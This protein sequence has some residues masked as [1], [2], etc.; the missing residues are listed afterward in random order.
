[1]PTFREGM[2]T[3]EEPVLDRRLKGLLPDRDLVK[4]RGF[5]RL[6]LDG[7][8]WTRK[9]TSEPDQPEIGFTISASEPEQEIPLL[10]EA[11]L[12]GDEEGREM[13]RKLAR[14][15]TESD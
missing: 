9:W 13:I 4:Q 7:G 10:C 1:M 11:Y 2:L 15:T 5:I 3:T 14:I 12:N 8:R 6:T